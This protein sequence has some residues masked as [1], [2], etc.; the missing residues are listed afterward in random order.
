MKKQDVIGFLNNMDEDQHAPLVSSID[1]AKG[2]ENIDVAVLEDLLIKYHKS[3][4][5][6]LMTNIES[7]VTTFYDSFEEFEDMPEDFYIPTEEELMK[8]LDNMEDYF[9]GDI[10]EF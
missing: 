1:K 9:D 7:E 6:S 8:D 3:N 5:A 2:G 4:A 10:V